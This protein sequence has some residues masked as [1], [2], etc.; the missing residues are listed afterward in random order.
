MAFARIPLDFNSL[1]GPNGYFDYVHPPAKIKEYM[2][3][4]NDPIRQR[5]AA[6]VKAL[7]RPLEKGEG[8]KEWTTCAI[9]ASHAFNSTTSCKIPA[10]SFRRPNPAIVGGN[11]HYIQA[12]DEMERWLTDNYGKTDD[13]RKL[14]TGP[15]LTGP[16]L[17][18]TGILIFDDKHVEFWNTT[19][20]VQNGAGGAMM[21]PE[22]IWSQPRILFWEIAITPS[23]DAMP[24]WLAGWWSVSD[25]AQYYYYFYEKPLVAWTWDKPANG[26]APPPKAPENQGGLSRKD[27]DYIVT[28]KA[29]AKSGPTIETY[30]PQNVAVPTEM[31]GKSN[32]FGPLVARKLP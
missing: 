10:E 23:L 22:F 6:K 17:G 31:K 15:D 5:N 16:I 28:W 20:I 32:K 7:G 9:Q 13:L 24:A 8:E 18:K 3:V 2:D 11:G 27:E 12:V 29:T 21:G 14:S 26:K 1:F 4:L 19:S 30:T 25:T